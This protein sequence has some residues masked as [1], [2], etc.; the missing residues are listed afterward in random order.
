[1]NIL[2]VDDHT[3]VRRGLREVLAEAYPEATI[4]EASTAE[5]ALAKLHEVMYALVILDIT[6]P[7]RGGMDA[8]PMI[9]ADHPDTAVLVLSAHSQEQYATRA[10]RAGAAGYLT[11]DSASDELV[12]AAR[13]ALAG[14][15]YVTAAVAERLA[16]DLRTEGGRPLH[17]SLSDREFQVLRMLAAGKSAKQISGEL[18]LS[19]KTIGTY[20][21]RILDKLE[22][23]STAE[24]IRYAIRVGLVD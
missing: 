10:L 8:L 24:L 16:K 14:G 7:G 20:R 23:T 21:S 13:K 3:M 22:M 5:Q 17:D 6:M 18:A 15:T 1:M 9:V 2:V 19:D 11:K 4:A 12:A